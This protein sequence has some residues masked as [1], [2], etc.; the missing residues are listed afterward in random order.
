MYS[1]LLFGQYAEVK[2][3]VH[4]KNHF[5]TDIFFLETFIYSYHCNLN[6]I[7]RTTLNRSVD[8]VSLGITTYYGITRIDIRQVAFALEYGF[9]ITLFASY[10]YALVHVFFYVRIILEIPVYQLFSLFAVYTQTFCKTKYG[11]AVNDTEV[12]GL[13]FAALFARYA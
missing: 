2:F 5:R 9:Y 12:G 4:W 11:Y 7:C 3:V 8:G 1:F 10:A 13:S 6:D